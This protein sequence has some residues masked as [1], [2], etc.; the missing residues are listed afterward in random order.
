MIP[1]LSEKALYK[2]YDEHGDLSDGLMLKYYKN[3]QKWKEKI[4]EMYNGN[5]YELWHEG[6]LEELKYCDYVM[7]LGME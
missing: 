2:L 1:G 5:M 4:F 7:S 6:W 3:P